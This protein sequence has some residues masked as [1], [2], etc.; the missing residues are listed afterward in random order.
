MILTNNYSYRPDEER[1]SKIE[2]TW[3]VRLPEEIRKS[4][5][6]DNGGVPDKRNFQ[7]GKR[8]RMIERFLCIKEK[9]TEEN[10]AWY[11]INVVL[12]QVE[13][14]IISDPDLVGYEIIPIAALFAGDYLCLDYRES[15]TP[16]VCVWLHEESEEWEPVTEKIAESFSDFMDMLFE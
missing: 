10:Y 2:K 5:M 11:D 6:K 12:S 1:L 9:N 7:C 15:D 13:E 4:L 14:R 3:G 16:S 8:T